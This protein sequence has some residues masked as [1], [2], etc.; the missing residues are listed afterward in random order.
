MLGE[1]VKWVVIFYFSGGMGQGIASKI[2]GN[3]KK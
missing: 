3:A 2:R 1:L